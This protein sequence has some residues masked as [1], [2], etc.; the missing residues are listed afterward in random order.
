MRYLACYRS[1]FWR[2]PCFA[3]L[4]AALAWQPDPDQFLPD[5]RP[6]APRWLR[7]LFVQRW[8][9]QAVAER[10]A[11]LEAHLC[12]EPYRF[13]NDSLPDWH[14]TAL[15]RYAGVSLR[16]L[17]EE[18]LCWV[19]GMEVERLLRLA[20]VSPGELGQGAWLAAALAASEHVAQVYLE[21]RRRYKA[22]RARAI[23]REQLQRFL[24]WRSPYE[25][26]QTE[27]APR[28]L[29]AAVTP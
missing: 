18:G 7:P 17:S 13:G 22:T 2:L 16:G 28:A 14:E 8:V 25:P 10:A 29:A 23:V 24:D 1:L 26:L 19:W 5:E 27:E 9:G 4:R 6:V 20:Q 3:P 12:L 21:W 11:W 15:L